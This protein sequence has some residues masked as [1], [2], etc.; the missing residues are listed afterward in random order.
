MTPSARPPD[1]DPTTESGVDW[2]ARRARSR[3]VK[4]TLAFLVIASLLPPLQP[5]E[6]YVWPFLAVVLGAEILI[7][8]LALVRSQAGPQRGEMLFF[9]VDVAAFVSFLPLERWL[10]PHPHQTALLA[11]LTTLRLTRLLVLL[12]FTRD[13]ARDVYS[14]VTRRE[15]LQQFGLVSAT[16]A[17]LA[18]VTAVVL[19][20][21]SRWIA[22]DYDGNP[23]TPDGFLDQIWW[24]FRQ[25]ESGD[26]LVSSLRANP[27]VIILSLTL[28][29]IGVFIISF[30]I[31]IGTNVVEQVILT[32]RRRPIGYAGHALVIGSMEHNENLVREFVRIYD[33]NRLLRRVSAREVLAWLRGRGPMPRRHALPR[34]ALLGP[35]EA[36]P[37]FLYDPVMRWV[38]YRQG[39]GADPDA[40]ERVGADGAKRVIILAR[41]DAGP[42]ADDVTV[43]TI[44]AF[45]ASNRRA[46]LFAEVVRSHNHDLV[47]DVG[48]PG[49]FPLDVSKFLGLFLCQ[50]LVVPGVEFLYRDL[51]NADGAEFYTHVWVH[52]REVDAVARLADAD[53]YIEFQALSRAAY[54]EQGVV[55]VGV[56]LGDEPVPK[57]A[58]EFIPVS[59]LTQWIN[60]E[61]VP[62]EGRVL[63]LGARPGMIPAA[64]LRGLI[65]VCESYL[66]LRR[67]ARALA[68]GANLEGGAARPPGP[69]AAALV[70]RVRIGPMG[71]KRVLVVGYS[72]ALAA[73]VAELSRFVIGVEVLLVLGERG[74]ES[75]P[76][77]RRL[78]MLGVGI[79]EHDPA[80]GE[81]G[82]EVALER[83]GR[84]TIFTHE[85]QDLA[86]F[87]GR[88]L[89]R[90]GA[91][92]AA[93]FLAEP[94]AL[95]RDAR[96]AMRVLRFARALHDG[97][98]PRGERLHLLA[99]FVSID[100][101]VRIEEHL[102]GH[103]CG[104]DDP[105]AM[106]VTLLSTE[107]I[108]NYFMVHSAF[109]P[110]VTAIYDE[111]LAERG[112][113]IV[114]IDLPGADSPAPDARISLE[115][116]HDALRERGCIPIAVELADGRVLL[117]PGPR[118][119][120]RAADLV[121]TFAMADTAHLA[122]AFRS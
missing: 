95:D 84:M 54:R 18:F 81:A 104:F 17:T 39:D 77:G 24:A 75:V 83:G 50:H 35:D 55:I 34:M 53:G 9:V 23:A 101:G 96:T 45:R 10:S 42:D 74:D 49:T 6:E 79:Q 15:Q 3:P 44:A 115:D 121:G 47:L 62:E 76:L 37:T 32:E 60:P 26:N 20:Q 119:T 58:R 8:A 117:N 2:L 64:N 59:R 122:A 11:V 52:Q 51:L 67:F 72:Q 111:I 97:A 93:V 116:L 73:L 19:S 16:V 108:K 71:P 1:T 112:Q 27:F 30:V 99:E 90:T 86:G 38:V 107:Q 12:R 41:P 65:A 28:T 102:L 33:K 56:F 66:P 91:V 82:R 68:S 48:G 106:R 92:E 100:R 63:E 21:T 113:E 31:G 5:V 109:V 94:N 103:R 43:A 36:P 80:P 110:G 88:V 85:G 29:I 7:R 14:I 118:E 69:D 87:A 13:L 114:R 4:V 120:F 78:A 22:H 98:V 40:L 25:L 70:A 57:A 61:T 89:K 105:R 46:H